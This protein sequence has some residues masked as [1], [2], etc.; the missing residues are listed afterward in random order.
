MSHPQW[1]QTQA[2]QVELNGALDRESVPAL[3]QFAQRW[4]PSAEQVDVSLQSIKRIDS[5]GMVMLIHLIEH[6]KK[7]NCHIMLSFVPAQLATLLKLSNV[8][9]MLADHIKNTQG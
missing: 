3:W 1:T 2:Q 7:R 6:A 9:V 8:D 5:A 4:Q